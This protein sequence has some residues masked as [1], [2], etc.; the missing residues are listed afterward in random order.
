MYKNILLLHKFIK[1]DGTTILFVFVNSISYLLYVINN[2][3][4]YCIILLLEE[5]VLFYFYK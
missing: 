5:K 1:L 4:Y 3:S 2:Y